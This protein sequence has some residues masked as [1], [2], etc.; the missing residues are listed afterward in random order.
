MKKIL[1]LVAFVPMLL[2]SLCIVSCGSDDD[3]TNPSVCVID[4]GSEIDFGLYTFY[5]RQR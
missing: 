3:G 5:Q 2:F 4:H 1:T